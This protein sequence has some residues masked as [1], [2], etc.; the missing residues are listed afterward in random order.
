MSEDN[1]K[2]RTLAFCSDECDKIPVYKYVEY[3]NS[4]GFINWGEDN[5]YPDIL[6]DLMDRAP[7][8]SSIVKGKAEMISLGGF[9]KE[10]SPDTLSFIRNFFA[11]KTLDDILIKATFDLEKFNTFALRIHWNTDRTRISLIDYI[12]VAKLRYTVDGVNGNTF[13]AVKIEYRDNWNK[14]VISKNKRIFPIFSETERSEDEYIYVFGGFSSGSEIYSKASYQAGLENIMEEAGI[15]NF[16]LNNLRKGFFPTLHINISDTNPSNGEEL[17]EVVSGY[18]KQ[19]QG[20][21]GSR[22]IFT[23]TDGSATNPT[24]ITPLNIDFSDS[25]FAERAKQ[26]TQNI[27]SAHRVVCGELFGVKEPNGLNFTKDQILES[28]RLFQTTYIN[29]RKNVMER[30][31]NIFGKIN[32]CDKLT[33]NDYKIE[34][35]PT[36]DMTSI[37]EIISNVSLTDIAKETLLSMIGIKEEEIKKLLTKNV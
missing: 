25:K 1:K 3:V 28:Y 12:D 4:R 33:I 24:T 11:G 29:P 37:I 17:D 18:K 16:H 13:T 36:Y 30:V 19:F 26:V 34:F 23:V 7:V 8:H 15:A 10:V 5:N 21:E 14:N 9:N 27:F 6:N 31:F 20:T 2:N 32:S 22:Q 35:D